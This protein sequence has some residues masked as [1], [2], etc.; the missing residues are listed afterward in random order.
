MDHVLAESKAFTHTNDRAIEI[1]HGEVR[2]IKYDCITWAI[3]RLSGP[4]NDTYDALL[5]LCH[6]LDE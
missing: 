6:H 5:P 2:A 1:L 3:D 4:V